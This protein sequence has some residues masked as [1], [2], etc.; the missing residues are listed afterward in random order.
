MNDVFTN[1][2]FDLRIDDFDTITQI[3]NALFFEIIETTTNQIEQNDS[4]NQFFDFD[5]RFNQNAKTQFA[6]FV[7]RS[8]QKTTRQH[9]EFDFQKQFEQ[10]N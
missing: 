2:V 7:Q 10:I 4:T 5:K 1:N 6:I 8:R 9:F 3:E